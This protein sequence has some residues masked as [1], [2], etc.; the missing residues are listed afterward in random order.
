MLQVL[1]PM[2][3]Y[4]MNTES[5]KTK[6]KEEM[7]DVLLSII[8]KDA[9]IGNSE[10]RHII[11]ELKKIVRAIGIMLSPE[12]SDVERMLDEF[13]SSIYFSVTEE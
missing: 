3:S 12:G 2:K 6:T 5:F 1:T 8:K 4:R 9:G 10:Y 7:A 11:V 13:S